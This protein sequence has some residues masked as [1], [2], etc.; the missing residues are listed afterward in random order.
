MT[1]TNI[2][3]KRTVLAAVCMA[4]GLVLPFA[5][6]QIP[7]FGKM[8]L[9]MH[10]PVLLCGMI[11][12]WQYGGAVGFCLPFL[13]FALFGM[14]PMPGAISMAFELMTY[15]LTAGIFYSLFGKKNI[16][17]TY[18]GLL[19]SMIAGRVVWGISQTVVLGLAGKGFTFKMFL[20]GAFTE[21]IPGILLQLVLIPALMFALKRA[22]LLRE[23]A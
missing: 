17:L 10:L 20:A 4:I 9:P 16:G 22:G 11:C 21:A 18:V 1:N 5:T 15:G 19:L 6:G 23:E 3:I 2:Q 7:Q 13:R 8:L 12:G 14:P